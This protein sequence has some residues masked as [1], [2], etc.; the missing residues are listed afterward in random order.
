[1]TLYIDLT[2]FTQDNSKCLRDIN[3]KD[4][5]INSEKTA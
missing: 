3:V 5:T 1:M 4:K 2:L